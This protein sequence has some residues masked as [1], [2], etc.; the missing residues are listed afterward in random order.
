MSSV[1]RSCLR[2]F[3][4]YALLAAGVAVVVYHR[5]PD[6]TTAVWSGII[7]G[8]FV[9]LVFLYLWAI[10]SN[11]LDW[12][13]LRPGVK[14]R[15][16]K[17]SAVIGQIRASGASLHAPFTK[18]PCV[19]YH[20]KI[21]SMAT[22]NQSTDYEGFALV[23]SY[24][25]TEEGQVRVMAYPELD[26]PWERAS[27]IEAKQRAREYI[28]ATNFLNTRGG[29]IK[30]L[31][32]ELKQLLADDDGSIRYDYRIEPVT[33]DLD[34]CR[35]EE[36][37]ILSGDTVCAVG[38]YSEERRALVPD[39]DAGAHAITIRKGEPGSFR[40]RALSKAFG[41]AVAVVIIT[42]LLA[43]AAGLF[44]VNF[45]MDA[46]E[47]M[48]PKR[49]FFWEELRLERWLQKNVRKP[50]ADSGSLNSFGM[51]FLTL[52]DHCA[53]GQLEANGRVV[54]L[55]YAS[56]WESEATRVMHIA[57]REGE[58]DG[59]TMTFD[60]KARKLQVAVVLNGREFVVPEEW[61]QPED[62]QT[63]LDSNQTMD[64]RITVLAPNDSIRARASARVPLEAR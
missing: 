14:P 47:Q 2:L 7:A 3:V 39:P 45:P 19:A 21:I 38:R 44:L 13:R 48:N 33:D 46:S 53:T 49:R 12:V 5:F 26:V 15:D 54:E 57:A 60:R 25:A 37:V 8:F 10:P 64:V 11:L 40:A 41:S 51:R 59:I 18:T 55:K 24:I 31:I 6:M 29:G 35:L 17:K 43:I 34:S 61:L 52:C 16:G 62:F 22:E 36:R 32:N 56:G 4:V 50:L 23:P 42:G 20:Y 63:A 30:G 28:A 1:A 58:R 27:G 9:W